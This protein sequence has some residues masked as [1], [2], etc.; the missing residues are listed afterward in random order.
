[1]LFSL[2]VISCLRKPPR[3]QLHEAQRISVS[4]V[5]EGCDL[6]FPQKYI[7]EPSSMSKTVTLHL[8][9]F[10][11]IS[12]F[13]LFSSFCEA[14]WLSVPYWLS[15]SLAEIAQYAFFVVCLF[16]FLSF[17]FKFQVYI[18]VE[19]NTCAPFTQTHYLLNFATFAT[20]PLV[21]H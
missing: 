15:V 18:K 4:Q 7:S 10:D 6:S 11:L 20:H 5:W 1:M 8:P 14:Y 2:I 19:R 13:Y 9:T 21:K 17:F 3:T 12:Y 16:F